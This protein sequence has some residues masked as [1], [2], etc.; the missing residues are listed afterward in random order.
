MG[1]IEEAEAARPEKHAGAGNRKRGM[2]TWEKLRAHVD[3][4]RATTHPSNVNREGETERSCGNHLD[5][6]PVEEA[7]GLIAE[8]LIIHV[9]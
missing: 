6:L 8:F 9:K 2:R 7:C 1:K 3:S 4:S 5:S